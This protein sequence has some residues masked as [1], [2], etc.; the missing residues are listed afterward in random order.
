MLVC[1]KNTA[2]GGVLE[3]IQHTALPCAVLFSQNAPLCCIFCTHVQQY[4]N[5]NNMQQPHYTP[6]PKTMQHILTGN[7]AQQPRSFVISTLQPADLLSFKSHHHLQSN[8]MWL[9]A[10]FNLIVFHLHK[11]LMWHEI[12]TPD[13]LYTHTK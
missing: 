8:Q 2:S 11:C 5:Y 6:V 12:C 13:R 7:S 4:F 10:C 1:T 3:Q 9:H